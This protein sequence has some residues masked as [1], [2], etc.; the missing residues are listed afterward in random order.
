[1][2]ALWA[3]PR[4]VR[5]V[6]ANT[7]R[8]AEICYWRDGTWDMPGYLELSS[9]LLDHREGLAVQLQPALFD[10][11]YITQR[12]YEMAERKTARTLITSG[13]RTPKTNRIVG[14]APGGL[15]PQAAALDGR[16][17]GVSLGVYARMLRA[18]QAGGVGL[19]SSH[20]H[21]DVGRAPVFWRGGARES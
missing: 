15:H 6:N 4:W 21:W 20:V 10:L 11:I 17:E 2:P 5:I 9:I 19:Y 3:Q 16:L 1:M 18:F 14:G 13:F 12:W 7:A 8:T